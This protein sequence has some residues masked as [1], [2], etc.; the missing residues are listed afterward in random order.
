MTQP[1]LFYAALCGLILVALSLYVIQGRG[2]FHIGL[3]DGGN[4]EM[5]TRIRMQANFVEYVPF[6]LLLAY[7][8]QSAGF[9]RWIVH[10]LCVV[11]VLSR[12]AHVAGL[13]TSRGAS[14]GRLIG[15]TGTLLVVLAA[16]VL[17]ALG[18]F[19]VCF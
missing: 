19:G 3:G 7:F 2:K 8:V 17:S 6:A 18:A 16:A 9:S 14:T 11:L 13:G 5:L 12:L 15:A 1:V 10:T 4:P